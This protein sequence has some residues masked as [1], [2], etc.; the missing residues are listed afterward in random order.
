MSVYSELKKIK[1][2]CTKR[3]TCEKCKYCVDRGTLK[4]DCQAGLAF[5]DKIPCKWDLN[6]LPEELKK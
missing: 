1:D 5:G 6:E 4:P 3:S 2:Y